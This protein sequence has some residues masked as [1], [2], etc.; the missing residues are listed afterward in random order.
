VK[1]N[2]FLEE[3][4]SVKILNTNRVEKRPFEESKPCGLPLKNTLKLAYPFSIIVALIMAAASVAGL[5]YRSVLYPTGELLLSF[6]PCDICNL[7]LGM[8]VLIA[9]LWLFKRKRSAGLLLWPGVLFYVVYMYLPYT[10]VFWGRAL[11]LVYLL[12]VVLSACAIVGII[13]GVDGERVRL[14]LEKKA[15]IRVSSGILVGLALLIIGRQAAQ[16]AAVLSGHA[17]TGIVEISTWISDFSV[18]V[19]AL[20]AVGI[21]FWRRKPFGFAAGAGLL[22]GYGMLSLGLIPFFLVQSHLDATPLDMGGMLVV[23]FMALLC[24]VPLAFFLRA[25]SQLHNPPQDVKEIRLPEQLSKSGIE[26]E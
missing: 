1:H 10:V 3:E 4:M 6:V 11:S 5:L 19:P 12:L 2:L 25:A 15:L 22:L 17:Q 7:V 21:Q 18:A 9:S 20:L 14:V 16:I 23:V 24:F 26:E 13:R 8:P